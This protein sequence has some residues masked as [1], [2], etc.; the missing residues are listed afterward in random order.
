[1]TEEIPPLSRQLEEVEDSGEREENIDQRIE[2]IVE[3]KVSQ[4]MDIMQRTRKQ[5]D[6][7]RE[8][9][10]RE[11][12]K[13]EKEYPKRK[14]INEVTIEA[15]KSKVEREFTNSQS[16]SSEGENYILR[17]ND[18]QR[19][20]F[21]G[22]KRELNETVSAI[23]KRIPEN[24]QD[25]RESTQ[26]IMLSMDNI[27]KGNEISIKDLPIITEKSNIS[28]VKQLSQKD[29]TTSQKFTSQNFALKMSRLD[30]TPPS[31]AFQNLLQNDSPKHA[32]SFSFHTHI[33]P[34][35]HLESG[36]DEFDW[37]EGFAEQ[38]EEIVGHAVDEVRKE[39]R[40]ILEK[41]LDHFMHEID[42]KIQQV[43]KLDQQR[44][45][46]SVDEIYR[47]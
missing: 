13:I 8:Y 6:I 4:R 15:N 45:E 17:Q 35:I 22:E 19:K 27:Q 38:V 41:S 42:L 46:T 24:E 16:D 36:E 40:V 44:L 31:R 37:L 11:Q 3:M 12:I 30:T 2:R 14:T 43:I 21:T 20:S 5:V 32:P 29:K 18:E 25:E 23:E 34:E 10:D 39:N 47:V 26:K 28:K 9:S 7:Q 33:P 1:V